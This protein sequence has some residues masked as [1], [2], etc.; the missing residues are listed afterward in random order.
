MKL[1]SGRFRASVSREPL[2][3]ALF[4]GG[5]LA[6]YGYK[7]LESAVK[8]A[9]MS[10]VLEAIKRYQALNGLDVDGQV[11]TTTI[12]SMQA[13]RLCGLPD[14]MRVQMP[15]NRADGRLPRFPV[16]EI[17]WCLATDWGSVAKT[18][19]VKSFEWAFAQWEKVANLKFFQADKKDALIRISSSPID[20]SGG[21]LAMSGL[22]NGA[23]TPVDQQY[24][25]LE[26]WSFGENPRQFT[27]DL[28]RVACHE[29]GHAL[30]VPHLGAGNLLQPTYDLRIR[31]PQKGDIAEM[32]ARYGPPTN[33]AAGRE[34]ENVETK[35]VITIKGSGVVTSVDVA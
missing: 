31:T 33:V 16:N 13:P 15:V 10:Q 23:G 2:V 25:S 35:F 11:G 28:G 8:C 24:D 6:R 3:E 5:Y 9:T 26:R 29:I 27:V 4:L 12:R 20:S 30:G 1:L 32:Q 21:T 7:T 19:V 14:V 18:N 17:G 34:V 22:A